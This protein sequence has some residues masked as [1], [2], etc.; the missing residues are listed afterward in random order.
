MGTGQS[1]LEEA[2]GARPLP[3]VAGTIY[4]GAVRP[5]R[6]SDATNG[7]LSLR[8]RPTAGPLFT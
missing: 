1:T 2:A 7:N 8:P 6:W 3:F 5:S 4:R